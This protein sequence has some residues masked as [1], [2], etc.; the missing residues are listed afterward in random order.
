MSKGVV[1][2]SYYTPNY[3]GWV[4]KLRDS[5]VAQKLEH[6]LVPIAHQT[7]SSVGKDQWQANVRYKP[8][9]ILDMLEKHKDAK[10]VVWVDADGLM[11]Q[12][13]E[14]LLKMREDLGVCFAPFPRK[15]PRK[16]ELLS[17]T[18]YVAN[19]PSGLKMMRLWVKAMPMI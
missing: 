12:K 5:L 6:D 3:K 13:P 7:K 15:Q 11:E 19:N 10:A 16:Y 17:G 2:I 14:L 1:F 8:Q 18:V 4:D 9:F